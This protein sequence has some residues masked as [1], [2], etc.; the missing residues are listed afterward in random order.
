MAK[1]Q[2]IVPPA[3]K[4]EAGTAAAPPMRAP[5]ARYQEATNFERHIPGLM[6]P[7]LNAAPYRALSAAQMDVGQSIAGAGQQVGS[8]VASLMTAM[9]ESKD[10]GDKSRASINFRTVEAAYEQELAEKQTPISERLALWDSKYAPMAQQGIAALKMSPRVAEVVGPELA[11]FNQKMR[12]GII[13]SAN[14][15]QIENDFQA[16]ENDYKARL[17]EGDAEG[18][19]E[20][21]SRMFE[22]RHINKAQADARLSDIKRVQQDY[23]I[24]EDI[25]RNPRPVL[26]EMM[27]IETTGTSDV[28][29]KIKNPI[30]VDKYKK[31]AREAVNSREV[32]TMQA[33]DDAKD[34]GM[35]TTPEDVSRMANGNLTQLQVAAVT[36]NLF[37][38]PEYDPQAVVTVRTEIGAY[39]PETDDE[40]MTNFWT[41]HEK[42]DRTIPKGM[43]GA[44]K[45]DLR[46]E[47]NRH[48]EGKP[49]DSNKKLESAINQE[50]TALAKAGMFDPEGYSSKEASSD[51]AY[52]LKNRD[53]HL[54]VWTKTEAYQER[55]RGWLEKNPD[56]TPEQVAKQLSATI[57]RDVTDSAAKIFAPSRMKDPGNNILPPGARDKLRQR[58]T[59][60]AIRQRLSPRYEFGEGMASTALDRHTVQEVTAYRPGATSDMG[61]DPRVEGGP[62]DAHGNRIL[63]QT[64]MEDYHA[65]RGEYVTVAMDKKSPWQS[66]FLTSPRYPGVV[67]KVMDNGGYGN[68]KTGRNWIDIA[69]TDPAQAR[70]FKQR[71]IPFYMVDAKEARR[72]AA[73]RE[74]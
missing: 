56:A 25:G 62:L 39:S 74:S 43:Q 49:K 7:E 68:N 20:V 64:T 21:V 1:I 30:L 32:E 70:K 9:Q 17:E 50:I 44:L 8:S 57:G 18:A 31:M 55:M 54:E 53:K 28:Y 10:A 72:I 13:N 58:L 34:A 67:F 52:L 16:Q 38:N 63:G 26:E 46:E 40:A 60:D 29:D 35:I 14:K 51:P 66:K 19:M 27:E 33:I 61:L 15:E 24:R 22:S 37:R 65:G 73:D 47:Y 59:P 3:P 48:R 41:L 71:N 6:Q 45:E 4:G 2:I 5:N 11:L 23:E 69:W 42:I 12:T 36:A